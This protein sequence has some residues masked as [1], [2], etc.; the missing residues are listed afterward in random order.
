MHSLQ[1]AQDCRDDV[2]VL[3][4]HSHLVWPVFE[5]SLPSCTCFH[6][7]K[8]FVAGYIYHGVLPYATI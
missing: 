6:S 3:W 7:E 4:C 8:N 5:G 1:M 2:N